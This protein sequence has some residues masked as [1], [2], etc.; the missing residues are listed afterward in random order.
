LELLPRITEILPIPI[1]RAPPPAPIFAGAIALATHVL[2]DTKYCKKFL[3]LPVVAKIDGPVVWLSSRTLPGLV[4]VLTLT[5]TPA[6][7]SA[8]V[9]WVQKKDCQ[10]DTRCG[11]V[12][13]LEV[14]YAWV[15]P[16][17]L[18]EITTRVKTRITMAVFFMV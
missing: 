14:K 1:Y 12:T 9:V 10:V 13:C 18:R 16:K 3:E 5:R 4:F 8:W 17:V 6:K 2:L 7:K 15:V 11:P